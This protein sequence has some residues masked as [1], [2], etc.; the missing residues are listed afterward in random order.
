[1]LGGASCSCQ[2]SRQFCYGSSGLLPQFATNAKWPA[3]TGPVADHLAAER[4]QHQFQHSDTRAQANPSCAVC[5]RNEAV[6]RDREIEDDRG[7]GDLERGRR[8]PERERG[9]R[10]LDQIRIEQAI[11]MSLRDQ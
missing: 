2:R 6:L 10:L 8:E 1:L 11:A 5:R 9:T 3:G 4:N 7:P